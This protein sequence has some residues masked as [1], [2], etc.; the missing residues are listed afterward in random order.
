MK[1]VILL[2]TILLCSYILNGQVRNSVDTTTF[3][4]FWFSGGLIVH[5]NH[6]ISGVVGSIN[7]GIDQKILVSIDVYRSTS[8][9]LFNTHTNTLND[10]FNTSLFVGGERVF[11]DIF[12]ISISGGLSIGSA[13]YIGDI[14]YLHYSDGF[15]SWDSPV[16]ESTNYQYVGFPIK[17]TGMIVS[18]YFGISMD[19]SANFQKHTEYML[20][21]CFNFGKIGKRK[22]SDL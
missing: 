6:E 14:S 19:L 4:S 18:K 5:T 10:V 15:N 12:L 8:F 20:S 9:D 2:Q 22:W 11:K 21:L 17:I 7:I 13:T 16:V 1:K 3:N